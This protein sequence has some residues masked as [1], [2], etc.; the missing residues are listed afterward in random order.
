M[1]DDIFFINCTLIF[2]LSWLIVTPVA[3]IM[4]KSLH[5]KKPDVKSY[6]WGYFV[7]WMGILVA[8]T[9][10]ILLSNEVDAVVI[11]TIC[12]FVIIT[13]CFILFRNRWI[14]IIAIILQLNPILWIINGIYLRNR[15]IEMRG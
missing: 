3:F 8:G 11:V 5:K 6:K 2:L 12:F 4:D 13:H 14:W 15:W 1:I 9:D 10:V 7:G